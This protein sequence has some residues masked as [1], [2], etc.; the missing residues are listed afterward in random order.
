M[1][2]TDN[3]KPVRTAIRAAFDNNWF[4]VACIELWGIYVRLP[5]LFPAALIRLPMYIYLPVLFAFCY[6]IFF[7]IELGK[8]KRRTGEEGRGA[9]PAQ[10]EEGSVSRKAFMD[11][12]ART[13]TSKLSYLIAAVC[14]VPPYWLAEYYYGAYSFGIVVNGI[15]MLISFAMVIVF[16][17]Y[18]KAKKM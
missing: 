8:T 7:V 17:A 18:R 16:L 3:R 4:Y 12:L 2:N 15:V 1:K 13:L 9:D 11:G 14:S 10:E 5:R 6:V